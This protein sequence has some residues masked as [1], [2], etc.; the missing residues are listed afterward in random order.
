MTKEGYKRTR[1]NSLLGNIGVVVIDLNLLNMTTVLTC[2][3]ILALWSLPLNYFPTI[4][5]FASGG[6][7]WAIS[8]RDTMPEIPP[9]AERAERAQKNHFENL[10]ILVVTLLAVQISG[11]A[12]EIIN[13][14]AISIVVF[15]IFH[16]FAYIIGIPL[17][18]S[19]AFVGSLLSLFVI[20]WQLIG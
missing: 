20:L 12:N 13:L 14:A 9:W 10:P 7:P 5:R 6:L 11:Q 4:A 19:L 16:G 15:R 18:R 3:L 1:L 17:L 8:N 2:A